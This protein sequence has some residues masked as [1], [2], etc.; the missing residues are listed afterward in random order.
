MRLHYKIN[1]DGAAQLATVWLRLEPGS[2]DGIR[3]GAFG[4]PH[5]ILR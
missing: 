5:K 2:V 4:L 1:L 3:G